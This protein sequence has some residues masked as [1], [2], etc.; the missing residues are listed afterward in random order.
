MSLV[1]TICNVGTATVV[2]TLLASGTLQAQATEATPTR[3]EK[4]AIG[5]EATAAG[6]VTL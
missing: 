2:L 6:S 5:K 3:A 4:A 1:T